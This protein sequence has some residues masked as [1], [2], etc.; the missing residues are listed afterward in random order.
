MPAGGISDLVAR[1]RARTRVLAVAAVGA[2]ALNTGIIT[3]IVAAATRSAAGALVVPCAV[4]VAVTMTVAV[5]RHPQARADFMPAAAARPYLERVEPV[6]AWM[7]AELNIPVPTVRI[8]DDDALNALSAASGRDGTVAYTSGLLDGLGRGDDDQ[9]LSAVT[10]HLMC[11]LSCGDNG[12]ALFSFGALAWALVSFDA[13]MWLVRLLRRMGNGCLRYA[14]GRNVRYGGDEAAF[15]ARLALFVFALALGIELLAAALALFV[16]GGILALVAEATLRALARQRLRFADAAAALWA[17]SA[18]PVLAALAG[19]DGEPTELA[20]G[21]VLLDDLC[22]AGPPAQPGYVQHIPGAGARAAWLRAAPAGNRAGLLVP[23]L[24]GAALVAVTGLLALVAVRVPYGQPFSTPAAATVG[25]GRTL[26]AP[27]AGSTSSGPGPAASPSAGAPGSPLPSVPPATGPPA[28]SQSPTATSASAPPSVSV[29]PS[30]SP[31]TSPSAPA[32]ATAPASLPPPVPSSTPSPQPSSPGSPAPASPAARYA[33]AVRADQPTAYWQFAG[34]AGPGGYADSSGHGNTLPEGSTAPSAPSASTGAGAIATSGG[35]T[36]TTSPLSPMSG[37]ASRTVEA[38]FRTTAPGCIFAAGSARHAM[39]FSLCVRNGPFNAPDPGA[40]G[41]YVETW[42]ADIFIPQS[43]P[44]DGS[45][46]Y[47]ALAIDGNTVNVVV[48][49]AQ[50]AGYIWDGKGY[51]DLVA[52]PFALPFTP[53][54]TASP[55]GVATGGLGNMPGGLTGKLAEVA[56]YPRA[57]PVADLVR[58]HL[59]LSG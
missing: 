52:Q 14:F 13:V 28:A 24:S 45:W 55:L 54:T 7:A 1:Q 22:F 12:L 51:G 47:L 27:I 49:G 2:A 8:I 17:G 48:D 39:A 19:L 32:S 15:Y 57:L 11:R 4:A 10:A 26:G 36:L 53:D 21:G 35:G 46:H 23:V 33:L 44:T 9:A 58:H 16:L 50:P 20:H 41:F 29:S 25:N 5:T 59:L 31:P 3:L 37:D 40:S 43:G 38:W 18:E 42:D 34:P 30:A 6:I 56:V